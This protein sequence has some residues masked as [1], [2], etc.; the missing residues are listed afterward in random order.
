[1]VPDRHPLPRIQDLLDTLGGYSMFS[2]LD[3]A[4]QH[5]AV[6]LRAEKCEMFQ[7]EVRYV[8]RLVSAEGV[9]IDPKDL[10]AVMALK[11]KTPQIVGDLRR[12]LGFLSYYR[13]YIQDFA[14]I[15]KPLY[16]LLQVKSSITQPL[17]RPC[18]SKGPQLPSKTPIIWKAE[19]QSTL[20][21]LVNMLTNPPVLAYPNF[22]EPFVLHTDASEKGLGAI[23]YQRQCGK[24]RVIGYGSRTLT[25][26][27]RNY[28]LHSGKLEFLALKWAVCEKFRDYLFYA[29]HFTIYTD[30][31]P[32]TYVM[33]TAKLNAV[34]H[35]WVGELSEFRFSIKYRPG[36]NNI[37]AD[38]LSRIPF[39]I[40]NYVAKCTEELSQDVLHATWEGMSGLTRKLLHEWNQLHLENG[41]LY[42]QTPE[43]KQLV[44]PTKYR[45]VAL[46]HLHDNMGH[47]GTERVLHL[48]R[49]R[50]YWPQMKRCIE[51]YVTRKCSCIKQKKPTT[52]I[53]APMGGLTSA[54]PLDLVCIDYLHLEKSKGGYEYILV[55]IDHFTRFA[56]AYP[57]KNK[58]GQTAAERIYNDYIP[59]LG[60]PNRL[61]HDQGREF[62]NSLFRT[63]GRLSGVGHSRTS[64]YH[65]QCN[66]AERFKRTLLQ[67][68]RTLT[69]R[70]KE[71]WK[72]HLPQ[73]IHAYNCTRHESTGYSPHY[74]MY[75]QHPRLPVDLLF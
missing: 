68:L 44:L 39:D 70:E 69:D 51:E 71:R 4:L 21:R 3:Q 35:R 6:K 34:G 50:F 47:V 32:L 10:E 15:A 38:T 63:L 66:P 8:G 20:E 31:N 19:H 62:E 58:S 30:N 75:G 33:S 5:H 7:K 14:K 43:R 28:R 54:S 9:R 56:Q 1:T 74:L 41:V 59:R 67:I 29:P 16:E 18:K 22:E 64:P 52:H 48:A 25:P 27:E 17:P 11:T 60:Y 72:E 23:L 26:A 45:S 55:V 46:K 42:R 37:D 24:M 12:I 13:S 57:T 2:I 40:D 61:H 73:M 53:R 65:P 49:E 36:K